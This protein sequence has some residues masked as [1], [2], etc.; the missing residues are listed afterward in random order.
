MKKVTLLLS[1]VIHFLVD[2]SCI[3]FL[4]GV[5]IPIAQDHEEW[6]RWAVFYNMMAFAVPALVGF[7]ADKLIRCHKLLLSGTGCFL[8]AGGYFLFRTPFS[9]LFLIGLGN[10]MFHVGAGMEV[11]K[12]AQEK[13]APPGMFIASGALGVFLGSTWGKAFIPLWIPFILILT[14]S[15]IILVIWNFA[16]LTSEKASGSGSGQQRP[17]D[18]G[19]PAVPGS[20]LRITVLC[21]VMLFIVVVIRSYYGSILGYGWKTGFRMGLLFTFCIAAGKF[22]GGIAADHLGIRPAVWLSLGLGAVT[23]LFSFEGPLPGCVSILLFNMTMPLTLSL[24]VK[25]LPRFPGFAFGFLML[26]LFLGTLPVT[27][28]GIHW[29]FSPAGL[30]MLCLVSLALLLLALKLSEKTAPVSMQ[31]AQEK[32]GDAL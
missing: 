15:G 27:P 10:G 26:A 23:A 9:A 24:L 20:S 28:G 1:T 11:L 17:V 8:V 30:A 13:Y 14:C 29:F 4:S 16:V 7:L 19:N 25:E 21:I 32:E 18:S 31:A 12:D 5:L 6:I 22:L 3:Y 2:L